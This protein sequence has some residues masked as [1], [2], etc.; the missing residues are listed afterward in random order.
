VSINVWLK[1]TGSGG[2]MFLS[3]ENASYYSWVFV[4]RGGEGTSSDEFDVQIRQTN[5]SLIERAGHVGS[6]IKDGNW[7]M[8]T[9]TWDGSSAA[10]GI[11]IYVDAVEVAYDHTNGSISSVQSS[12]QAAR[13][14]YDEVWGTSSGKF[15]EL[16][17]WKGAA[18]TPAD[19]SI[20]YAGG[21]PTRY[22]T[23][24]THITS[25]VLDLGITPFSPGTFT[26]SETKPEG[27]QISYQEQR[28]NNGTDWSGWTDI[29]NSSLPSGNR[30]FR[31][32]STFSSDG[33]NTPTLSD[34]TLSF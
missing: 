6:S 24:G 10:S 2:N 28:S 34:Y 12:S 9:M 13:I 7:H 14:G 19:V 21:S 23:S 22:K 8:I 11:H 31:I 32:K 26:V 4:D 17:Y 1:K 33:S 29:L 25:Q 18:L 30:Y 16:I 20:L 15:D 5:S 27:T 3:K